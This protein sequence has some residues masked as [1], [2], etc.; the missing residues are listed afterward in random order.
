[1][2][3]LHL[4]DL[5]AIRNIKIAW[6]ARVRP[7][8]VA[9]IGGGQRIRQRHRHRHRFGAGYDADHVD[10]AAQ[11]SRYRLMAGVIKIEAGE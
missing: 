9:S 4:T 5:R 3:A 11:G 10:Q 2:T 1:M 6:L 7:E 8:A